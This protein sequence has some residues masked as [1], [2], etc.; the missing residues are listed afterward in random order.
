MQASESE[1]KDDLLWGA[2]AIA[3]EIGRGE[4]ATYHLLERGELPAKKVCGRWVATKSNLRKY[5]AGEHT[6]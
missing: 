6:A 2:W 5:L 3:Q 4:R 1:L